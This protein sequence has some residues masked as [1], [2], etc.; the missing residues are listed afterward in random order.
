MGD[1]SGSGTMSIYFDMRRAVIRENRG[2]YKLEWKLSNN[3]N[4]QKLR[5][6]KK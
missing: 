1:R 6:S 4:I 5:N 3:L 2:D